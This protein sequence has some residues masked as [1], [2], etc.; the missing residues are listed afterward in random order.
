MLTAGLG[1][2]LD[3]ITRLVAKPAVPLGDHTI[4]E[5]VL[6]W[7]VRQG[8]TDAVLNLHHLPET[9]T[10]IVG[11]GAHLGLRVR[12]SWETPIL[13]SAGGPRRALPLLDAETFVIANGDTLC[14]V[15]LGPMLEAHRDSG[16]L[17]TTAVVP[18]GAP[19]RYNGLVMDNRRRVTGFVP[20]GQAAQGSWHF[21]GIQIV[22]RR[23]FEPLEDGVP[24]ESVHG[25][26]RDLVSNANGGWHGYPVS[27][28]FF[29]VGTPADYLA[30]ASHFGG[31]V[32]SNIVWPG[33]TIGTGAVLNRCIVTNVEL[34][35]GFR[36]TDCVL[37]PSS[38][39]RPD[40]K[41]M[42]KGLVEGFP[43]EF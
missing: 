38:V 8:V 36:A 16:A 9:I 10:A 26:Y 35:S 30:A 15:E 2:R 6:T 27:T 42:T 39:G 41:A 19:D 24:A 29:D 22:S 33:A 31:T 21:V 25:V 40:D 43:I 5:R 11:D 1:V 32:G 12:Y 4:I 7:L 3:P 20:R 23:V 37:V 13:G 34:P 28:P 17:V 14:D 18:N